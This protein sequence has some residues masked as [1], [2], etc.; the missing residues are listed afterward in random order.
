MGPGP[1]TDGRDWREARLD[2]GAGRSP[3]RG[4][5]SRRVAPRPSVEPPAVRS[6]DKV[7]GRAFRQS[8]QATHDLVVDKSDIRD[9]RE[10]LRAGDRGGSRDAARSGDRATKPSRSAAAYR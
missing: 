4:V 7:D 2:V 9:A 3:G 10:F 6:G 5:G 1:G 8:K